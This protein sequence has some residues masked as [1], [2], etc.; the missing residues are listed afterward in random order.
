MT[1][2]EVTNAS[3]ASPISTGGGGTTFEQHVNAAF[4]AIML[5]NGIPPVI[6]DCSIVEAH[7]QANHK[8]WHTDDTLLV[9]KTVSGET[10]NLAVQVKRTFTVSSTNTECVKAIGDFWLDFQNPAVFDP[11]RDAFSLVVQRG[12]DVLLSGLGALLDC[13]R[14]SLNDADF[15][16]R[17]ATPKLLSKTA[18]SHAQQIREIIQKS[19]SSTVAGRGFWEF[20]KALHV[21]SYD[22]A[23][24]TAQTEALIKTMLAHS[25]NVTDKRGAANATWTELVT[26]VGTSMPNAGS[27]TAD[28][29][30]KSCRE[31]HSAIPSSTTAALDRMRAHSA[32]VTRRIRTQ[33]GG[34]IELQREILVSEV[35]DKIRSSKVVLITAPAGF[36]KSV[37]AR[38]AIEQLTESSSF[39][40]QAEEFSVPHLDTALT[41]AQIGLGSEELFGLLAVQ[42]KKIIQVESVERLLESPQREGFFDLLGLAAKDNNCHVVLTCR[43][44]SVE[45]VKNAFLTF[46]GI[47][48]ETVQV[49]ELS[50]AEVAEVITQV[51]TLKSPSSH[52]YLAE[53]F[54]NPYYL[55]KAARMSWPPNA[56]LPTNEK[57]FRDKFWREVVRRDDQ[58]HEARP[59]RREDTFT[60]VCLKRAKALEPYAPCDDLNREALNLLRSDSLIVYSE[61]TDSLAAPAHD[62]LEDWAIIRW[63]D[64]TYFRKKNDLAG[65]I[66]DLGTFPAVRRAYRK[67]LTE[68]ME[69]DPALAD[70]FMVSVATS[71]KTQQYFRDDTIVAAISAP[72]AADFLKRLKP[73]LLANGAYLLKQVIHLLRVACKMTAPWLKNIG[74]ARSIW[75]V[76]TGTA[77]PAILQIVNEA[78]EHM[79][80]QDTGL[81]VGLLTDWTSGI[82]WQ[83]HHPPGIVDAAQIAHR[84]LPKLTGYRR[85]GILKEVL[86]VVIKTPKGDEAAFIALCKRAIA[87]DHK[88]FVAREF[89]ELLLTGIRSGF[90]CKDFPNTMIELT[91]AY[92]REPRTCPELELGYRQIELEH[93]FGLDDHLHLEFYPASAS[94]GPFYNLLFFH[95]NK[96]VVFIL[97]LM[98]YACK[99]F[100]ERHRLPG[101]YVDGPEEVTLTLPD[102]TQQSQWCDDRL[103]NM[104]RG[105]SVGPNVLQCALMALEAWLLNIG[106][107]MPQ[108]LEG[109]LTFLLKNSNNVAITAIVSSVALAYPRA[110]GKAGLALLSCREIILL[111]KQRLIHDGSPPSRFLQH[112]PIA[113]TEDQIYNEERRQSDQ[114]VHRKKDLE[115]LAIDLAGTPLRNQVYSLLDAHRHSL[116]PENEQDDR[117]RV[118]GL[119]LHRMDFRRFRPLPEDHPF[120]LAANA[121]SSNQGTKMVVM[122]PVGLEPGLES[123]VQKDVPQRDRYH[124]GITL[125][126]WAI[127][128]FE[129]ET[130]EQYPPEA[131]RERLKEA[132]NITRGD[133]RQLE[134]EQSFRDAPGFIAAVC[135]RDHWINMDSTEQ[136]WCVEEL[137]YSIQREA[138]KGDLDNWISINPMDSSRSAAYV[139]PLMLT[140]DLDSTTRENVTDLIITSLSHPSKEVIEYAAAGIGNHLGKSHPTIVEQFAFSLTKKTKWIQEQTSTDAYRRNPNRPMPGLLHEQARPIVKAAFSSGQV[141]SKSDIEMLDFDD[142]WGCD[143]LRHLLTM[144]RELFGT[145]SAQQC[146]GRAAEVLARRWKSHAEHGRDTHQRDYQAEY[147]IQQELAEFLIRVPAADANKLLLPIVDLVSECPDE[148]E[149]FVKQLIFAVDRNGYAENF[150]H[151]WQEFARRTVGAKWLPNLDARYKDSS[152][153]LGAMFLGLSW[154]DGVRHWPRL[155]GFA[156]LIDEFFQSLPPKPT[157]FRY[158]LNFLFEIGEH[159]LPHA[160][161]ILAS[162]MSVG[163]PSHILADSNSRFML[164]G[165]LRPFVYGKPMELKTKSELRN[166]VLTLLDELVAAGSSA[167]YRMRDDFVTPG[168]ATK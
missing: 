158:Y 145:D 54:R 79:G 143:V 168:G 28:L 128:N 64:S 55:D 99:A 147:K 1:T 116:P 17:L 18:I 81:L 3:V 91:N 131:W 96:A 38:R 24:S 104:Y 126:M 6:S 67:W 66:Q 34:T 7:F 68:F 142:W 56:S 73:T 89:S 127:T 151:L 82:T 123:F 33:I 27:L 44:Y 114:R 157:V 30:P 62:A 122:S 107:E 13:A 25:A 113:H 135:V 26:F 63:I 22:L 119:A 83:N 103:W 35:A 61:Q 93:I 19:T 162:R 121:S 154:K 23:T 133:R 65:F 84:L 150:W 15:Q 136:Q 42:G 140:F 110:A 80:E 40:F 78:F 155:E 50:E 148:V 8:N 149:G 4:L 5:V 37:V 109:W 98:N 112:L 161:V 41:Q 92:V 31:R 106:E 146:Y 130:K 105:T 111:D 10:R 152:R 21:L 71:Q 138:N 125:F 14:A 88:D 60:T 12:T 36:G 69:S 57:A 164:E 53:L 58:A 49:P 46:I 160:F 32:T 87:D 132:Q 97:D 100:S 117:D 137:T 141:F 134:R 72:N 165:L 115:W 94:R 70:S 45:I 76:P 47:P 74:A 129:R 51:P 139:L 9:G 108:N 86:E 102:G 124:Q 159:S 29:L 77:W 11:S 118:W 16:R 85:D 95:P 156:H 144:F 90:A 43:D 166:A 59:H 120:S 2:G 48:Y 39:A 20:L 153:F 167:A 163:Q 101:S 52:P 75:L